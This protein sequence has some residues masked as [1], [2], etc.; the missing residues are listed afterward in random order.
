MF[1]RDSNQLFHFFRGQTQRLGLDFNLRWR[2]FGQNVHWHVAKLNDAKDHHCGCEDNHQEAKM[3]YRPK[4]TAHLMARLGVVH[5]GHAFK[6]E[7][8]P[9]RR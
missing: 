2:E 6:T 8:L 3:Q 1:Q 4:E 7:R 5:Q 9:K